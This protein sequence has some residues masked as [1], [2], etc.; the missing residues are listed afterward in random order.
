MSSP[1]VGLLEGQVAVVTGAAQGIGLATAH[2][3]HANGS[4]VVLADT[5]LDAAGAAARALC[6]DDRVVAWHVDITDPTSVDDLVFYAADTFGS[7]STWINNAGITRDRSM[8]TMTVE[9]FT[10]VL[11]VNLTGTWNC[12]RAVGN[13]M[14]EQRA[15]SIV[16]LSSLSGKSGNA[17]QTNY[18]AAK[19]GVVG[20]TKA[21]A[22][23]LGR[24]GVRVNA[25]QPGLIRTPMTAQM[26][27]DV[28][29]QREK[30]IPLGRAGE[31][32]EVAGVAVFLA[33]TLSSYMTGAVLEVGGGRFM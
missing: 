10:A 16:N 23:E 33:S 17:G 14:R 5:N 6:D 26:P 31:P 29:A 19:A 22:K 32:S 1:V 28:F 20:L 8:R 18:S 11:Q 3:L 7:I 13:H 25:I 21:A 4:A 30:E 9:D 24:H 15:G 27:Q 12:L 2:A